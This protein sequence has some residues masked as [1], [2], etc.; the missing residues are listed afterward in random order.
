MIIDIWAPKY[1]TKQ[2]LIACYKVIK[3]QNV[4]I[5]FTRA[6]H[7]KGILYEVDYEKVVNSPIV[8]NGKIDC[9]AVSMSDLVAIDTISEK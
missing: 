4:K 1:S 2:C 6:N 5:R 7:L 8:T 9:Y 3:G